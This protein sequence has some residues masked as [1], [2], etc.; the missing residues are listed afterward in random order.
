MKMSTYI[1]CALVVAFSLHGASAPDPRG[2]TPDGKRA[3]KVFAIG[4]SYAASLLRQMPQVAAD[5]GVEL[6][7]LVANIGGCSME[8][9]VRLMEDPKLD[10]HD[11]PWSCNYSYADG[12]RPNLPQEPWNF[13]RDA[14]L[15]DDWDIITVQQASPDSWR[16]E[17]YH[18][19]GDNLVGRVRAL[20]PEAE[21]VVQ[22]TWSDHP[23]GG[24]LKK[25]GLTT[26]EMYARLHA[27]CADFARPYGYRIIPTGAAVE[28][29]RAFGMMQKSVSDP[30]LNPSGQFLQALVW[31][32]KLYGLDVTKGSYVPEGM[33][34]A[35][36]KKLREV[37]H[38][39]VTAQNAEVENKETTK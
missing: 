16:P 4:N 29:A 22:E 3:F 1:G 28:K 24:R 32:E 23:G 30:H 13:L 38:A 14:I 8:K 31:T 19:W 7:L 35:F 6:D 37:A 27:A 33:D 12:T 39:A 17:T 11:R 9:H 25:W 26:E 5:M 18:P 15:A 10:P 34:A 36:A 21:I 20:C 2:D